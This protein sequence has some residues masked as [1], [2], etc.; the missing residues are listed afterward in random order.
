MTGIAR[1]RYIGIMQ[2]L[3]KSCCYI[4]TGEVA[5]TEQIFTAGTTNRSDVLVTVMLI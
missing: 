5:I 4:N 3:A 1:W 2:K